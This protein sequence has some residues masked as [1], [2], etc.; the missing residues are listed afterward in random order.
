MEQ[1]LHPSLLGYRNEEGV[2][3]IWVERT[4]CLSLPP[5]CCSHLLH[6][7]VIAQHNAL[8]IQLTLWRRSERLLAAVSQ[9]EGWS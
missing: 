2:E 9:E 8:Q 1:I 6:T 7:I 4:Q 3:T 5:S